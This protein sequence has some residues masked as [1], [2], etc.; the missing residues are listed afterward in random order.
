MYSVRVFNINDIPKTG[1]RLL[2]K[3]IRGIAARFFV[4]SGEF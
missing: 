3:G 2:E 1:S 4:N